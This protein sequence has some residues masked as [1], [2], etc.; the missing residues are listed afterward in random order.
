[1]LLRTGYAWYD[2]A[3]QPTAAEQQ[4]WERGLSNIEQV[5][6]WGAAQGYFN[7]GAPADQA[8]VLIAAQQTRFANWVLDGRRQPHAEVIAQIQADFVRLCCR[9][10]VATRLLAEDGAGLAPQA[11]ERIR[12]LARAP[13]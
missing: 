8:R 9:P 7:A 11:L 10:R 12:A 3:A 5:L 4:M 2:R 13:A 1:M 6:R